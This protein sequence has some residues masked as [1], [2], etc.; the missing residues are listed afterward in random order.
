MLLVML[1]QVVHHL[2]QSPVSPPHPA[3]LDHRQDVAD[4]DQ[5]TGGVFVDF[6]HALLETLPTKS[7]LSDFLQLDDFNLLLNEIIS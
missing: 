3:P 6:K 4:V 1:S 7:R 5:S 2:P